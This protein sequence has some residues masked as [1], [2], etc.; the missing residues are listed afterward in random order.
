MDNNDERVLSDLKK[1][2]ISKQLTNVTFV[3]DYLQLFF[4][5]NVFNIYVFPEILV[6][7]IKYNINDKG[8]RDA[9]CELIS[10]NVSIIEWIEDLSIKIILQNENTITFNLAPHSTP[11]EKLMFVTSENGMYFWD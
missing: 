7:K 8:Y 1:I 11:Y 4:E 3:M 9:I 5:G 2:L 6:N 10:Q